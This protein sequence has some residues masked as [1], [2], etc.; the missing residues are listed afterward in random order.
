M[1]R[2][3]DYWRS[4]ASYRVRL[5]L[6]LKG[7]AYEIVPVN[8]V[9]GEQRGAANLAINPQG[10][11]PTLEIDGVAL[12]QSLAIIDYLD[13]V[14]PDPPL[15]PADPIERARQQAMALIIAADI[16]PIDNPRVLNR[17]AEQF[18]ADQ[19]GRSAWYAH[20]ITTGFDALE[21]MAAPAPYLGGAA[22]GLAD[23]C[24]VPQIYNARRFDV[25]L[26]A[27]PRLVAADAAA[28]AHPAF[29]AAHPDAI[30]GA[31]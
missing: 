2:L 17:L 11:V 1:L 7:I 31:A 24:L 14:Y 12:T 22:P 29:Q 25:P 30:R 26:D 23:I 21:S 20:W 4:S 3:H 27:Y 28:C 6:A 13:R 10:L 18:G 5:A 19:A 9:A 16:H 15:L 8:L